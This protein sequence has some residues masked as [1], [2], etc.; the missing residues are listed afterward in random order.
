MDLRVRETILKELH[1]FLPH[2]PE[3]CQ[4]VIRRH[5]GLDPDGECD[6]YT[7]IGEALG[8]S[9]ERV[10]QL[11]NESLRGFQDHLRRHLSQD[12]LTWES[13][14]VSADLRERLGPGLVGCNG[15]SNA[16]AAR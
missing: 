6:T 12:P 14:Q 2:L 1:D 5:L 3:R 4:F 15:G 8:I 10:R 9:G 13:R 11:R 7:Q 16:V